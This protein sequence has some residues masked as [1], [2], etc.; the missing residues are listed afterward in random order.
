MTPSTLRR[1]CA[2]RTLSTVSGG[3]E[4]I[5]GLPELV[6]RSEANLEAVAEWV[7]RTP[8]VDFLAEDPAIRSSTSICLKIVDP[9]SRLC[10]TRSGR[11][12]QSEWRLCWRPR[13]WPTISPPIGRRLRDC[14]S[15]AEPP[16]SGRTWKL[17]SPG[18]IGPMRS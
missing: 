14:V 5:G 12:H 9:G 7:A 8:W 16:C 4:E 1:C 10:R 6:R 18:W 13:A 11:K 15:G 17:S 3:P 2:W